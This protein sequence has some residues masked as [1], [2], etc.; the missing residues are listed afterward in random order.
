MLGLAAM[1]L[2]MLA[3]NVPLSPYSRPAIAQIICHDKRHG[4]YISTHKFWLFQPSP[5]TKTL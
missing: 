2:L 3:W 4:T 5:Q 1:I